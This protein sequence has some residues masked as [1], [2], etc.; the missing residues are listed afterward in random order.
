MKVW[1]V[2][3]A[4]I[5]FLMFNLKEV[6]LGSKHAIGHHTGRG[7]RV[8]GARVVAEHVS[9]ERAA[10]ERVAGT[11]AEEQEMQQAEEPV[12]M[13]RVTPLRKSEPPVKRE[14]SKEEVAEYEEVE[15][16]DVARRGV[17]RGEMTWRDEWGGEWNQIKREEGKE[18][19]FGDPAE[20]CMPRGGQQIEV[21]HYL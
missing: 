2:R 18:E 17:Q 9:A 21:Q 19:E 13:H 16:A 14:L 5:E 15:E 4:L 7:G 6:R 8:A 10:G 3:R 11:R 20:A 1:V 12:H